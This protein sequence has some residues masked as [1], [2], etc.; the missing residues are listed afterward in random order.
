MGAEHRDRRRRATRWAS[1]SGRVRVRARAAARHAHRAASWRCARSTRSRRWPS[2]PRWPRATTVFADLAE[3]RVK[4]SDRIVAHRARAA[5][6]RRHRRGAP[7]RLRRD[8]PRRTGARG[9]HRAARA[10]SPHRDGGRRAGPVG[11]RRDHRPRRRHRDVVPGL[12]RHAARARRAAAPARTR[13]LPKT[14]APRLRRGA[15]TRRRA[16]RREQTSTSSHLL[17]V[18]R[19]SRKFAQ[20]V[21]PD[22]A[23]A[24]VQHGLVYRRAVGDR[25]PSFPVGRPGD[26]A[27]VV[28]AYASPASVP[29]RPQVCSD[30]RWP[31][32]PCR[33][34]S[35]ASLSPRRRSTRRRRSS[36]VN[37]SHPDR[38]SGSSSRPASWCHQRNASATPVT[39]SPPR[40]R[41]MVT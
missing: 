28:G 20:S 22:R 29:I 40:L 6:R 17:S 1:P 35:R 34:P 2:P 33:A 11:G 27:G 19:K 24:D 38:P 10:R 12:R 16:G 7:R 26:L 15:T 13:R 39:G 5:P 30:R 8:R 32:W 14:V 37:P 3:L 25:P 31:S 9:R 4:E 23:Q 21:A 18:A 41:T 36:Q